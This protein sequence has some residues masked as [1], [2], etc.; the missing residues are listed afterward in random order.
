MRRELS[1]HPMALVG[2]ITLG[3]FKFPVL[4]MTDQ[5]PD[6][7]GW[8]LGVAVL[9][10]TVFFLSYISGNNFLDHDVFHEMALFRE[11]LRIGH[12][13]RADRFAY[14]P[15]IYPTIHHE[16]GSGAIL[17]LVTTRLGAPG[18][19]LLKY[20][21]TTTVAA[22]SIIC[23][24]RRGTSWPVLICMAPLAVIIGDIGFTTIRAQLFSLCMVTILLN[25]LDLDRGGSWRWLLCWVPLHVVWLNLHAGFVVGLGFFAL[26]TLEQ[27]VRRQPIGHL[28]VAGA[29]MLILTLAN[30]Y[31]LPYLSYLWRGVSMDRPGVPE[32]L[33]LWRTQHQSW[34]WIF[35]L[36][37][38][39]VA[40]SLREVGP[41]RMPGL[42][43]VVVAGYESL[44]HARHLSLFAVTWLCY[45]P[46]FVEATPLGR[47]VTGICCRQRMVFAVLW[48][49]V[50]AV[51]LPAV[52]ADRFWELKIPAD[53]SYITT[54]IP[55]I[56]P[57]GAES[58][59]REVHFHGNV[60][61]PFR[62]GAY[63]SWKLAP[64]VK[65]SLDGRY[66]VAYQPGLLG[67]NYALYG[68][69][70]G[71]QQVLRK[72]PTDVVL[73]P[74]F[75]PLARVMPLSG[76]RRV[77]RDDVYEIYARPGLDLPVVDRRGSDLVGV[78]P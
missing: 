41:R 8:P 37:L 5:S 61:L 29:V 75:G 63:M 47:V 54:G 36:A 15:T 7:R 32:W 10:L 6:L 22:G 30:P 44:M 16:W 23:A 39:L 9:G 53:R 70:P 69:R 71:W 4:D 17:Y 72:Y 73:V 49:V 76:W 46:G 51:K 14:T 67:E 28:L 55:Y 74:G 65:V 18:I 66:E 27:A 77:Y 58:Y 52:L 42:L 11:A 43:L 25:L 48:L 38:G 50:A 59:L 1:A 13:P 62:V 20:L 68:A 56:F 19:M 57:V 64:D 12:I 31:G 3:Q 21:L 33:P 26:H 35:L 2:S 45:A 24:R 78:L 34:P 60:M 40:Y